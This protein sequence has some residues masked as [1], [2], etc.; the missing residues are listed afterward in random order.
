CPLE[1]CDAPDASETS[2]SAVP[3]VL[4]V[5]GV[6]AWWSGGTPAS[7]ARRS[8]LGN[9]ESREQRDRPPAVFQVSNRPGMVVCQ[10]A[11]SRPEKGLARRLAPKPSASRSACDRTRHVLRLTRPGPLSATAGRPYLARSHDG[12]E[13]LTRD[14]DR[15]SS[16]S[17]LVPLCDVRSRC[18]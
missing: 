8:L 7:N 3:R 15:R 12:L 13:Q 9:Q 10:L 2:E 4:V 11:R 6:L 1:T 5:Q 18:D 16:L 14:R 17:W